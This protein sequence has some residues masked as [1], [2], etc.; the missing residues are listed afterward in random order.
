MGGDDAQDEAPS[1]L[2]NPDYERMGWVNDVIVHLWP[3]AW[4]IE[5]WLWGAITRRTRRRAG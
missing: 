5:G 2:K 4:Q 1:W 3:H